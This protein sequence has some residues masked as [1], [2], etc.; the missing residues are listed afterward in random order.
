MDAAEAAITYLLINVTQPPMNDLR[1]RRA[2]NMAINKETYSKAKRT[3]KPLS[4]FTPV[5]IF[6]GYPQPK[7]ESVRSRSG[8]KV[9]WEK[10]V[11]R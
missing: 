10:R 7:G 8:E 9:V 4:A 1:V 11:F 3:T 6:V 5:G 2:F